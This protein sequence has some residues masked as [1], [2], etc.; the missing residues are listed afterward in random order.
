[1]QSFNGERFV[2][3]LC[4]D[5]RQIVYFVFRISGSFFTWFSGARFE[6][7]RFILAWSSS[8]A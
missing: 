5:V 4:T 6:W 8:I 2:S 3:S 7:N 1:M